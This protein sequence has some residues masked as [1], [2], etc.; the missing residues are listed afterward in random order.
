MT[1][2]TLRRNSSKTSE[3]SSPPKSKGN[4]VYGSHKSIY[5]DLSVIR[6]ISDA[7][8]PL[9]QVHSKVTKKSY[10]MKVYAYN[11]DEPHLYYKNRTRYA[12]LQHKNVIRSLYLENE[13]KVDLDD[14]DTKVSCI[15]TEYAPNGSLMDLL[16]IH[17][18]EI[19]EVLTRTFFRQLIDGIEYLHKNHVSHMDLSLADLLLDADYHLKIGGFDRAHYS[20]DAIIIS[21]GTKFFRAPEVGKSLCKIP[22]AA[23]IYSAGIIL[24]ILRSQGVFPQFEGEKING[25]K[26]S[27]LMWKDSP[28]FWDLH[29]RM[30]G[31]N[32]AVY[33]RDFKELFEMMTELDPKRRA[34]I[35]NIKSSSWYNGP[36]HSDEELKEKVGGLFTQLLNIKSFSLFL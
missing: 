25:V 27:E 14:V 23:D 6:T 26:F 19:D 33:D 31:K 35:E 29:C 5:E 20:E 15:V 12:S 4:S 32:G 21:K 3:A 13:K 30:Q 16:K 24:F 36:V 7:K 1:T 28:T 9:Y 11:H 8:S 17:R 22:K 2:L 34:S 10:A 18:T